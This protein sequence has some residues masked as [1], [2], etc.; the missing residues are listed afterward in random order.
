MRWIFYFAIILTGMVLG[1]GVAGAETV[2]LPDL[3]G[4][5]TG[6]ATGHSKEAGF[7]EEPLGA[8]RLVIHEQQ[9]RLFYGTLHYPYEGSDWSV[10]FSGG[11]G[12]DMETLY[13]AE[14]DEGFNIGKMLSPDELEIIYIETSE[15]GMIGIDTFVREVF[16]TS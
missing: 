9:G 14:Y 11:I 16:E 2:P 3:V 10:D 1:N 12:P 6:S 7:F 8:Y 13:I 15:K 5:W 4:N